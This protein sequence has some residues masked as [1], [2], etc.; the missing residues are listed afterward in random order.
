MVGMHVLYAARWQMPE[1][2]RLE[3][4]FQLAEH[5]F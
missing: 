4:H 1:T 5:D 3:Q 2:H